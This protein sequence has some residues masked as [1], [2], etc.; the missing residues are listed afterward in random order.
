MGLVIANAASYLT[1]SILVEEVRF[2]IYD[3][4]MV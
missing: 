4:F 2:I 3:S 1:D